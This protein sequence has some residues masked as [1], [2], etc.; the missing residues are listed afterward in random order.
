MMN[1][2]Q[3]SVKLM[4]KIRVGSHLTRVYDAAQTPLDRVV[5]CPDANPAKVAALR[6]LRTRLDPFVLA[7]RIDK[8]L[9]R[10]FR[11]ATRTRRL[12]VST[13]AQVLHPSPKPPSTTTTG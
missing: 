3:P 10:I 13:S 8:H 9:E 2:F 12:C 4:K 6:R 1:L 11:L 7:Q 5:A